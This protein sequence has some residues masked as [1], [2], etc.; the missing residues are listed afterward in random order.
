MFAAVTEEIGRLLGARTANM[1]RFDGGTAASVVGAW[2]DTPGRFVPVGA[3]IL[4]DSPTALPLVLTTGQTARV[5]DYSALTGAY[6]IRL[7]EMIGVKAAV[8]APIRVGGRLWGA[9]T[10][11]DA[12][13]TTRRRRPMPSS[14]SRRSP[15]S[16][17][18][19]SRTPRPS[20]S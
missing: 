19:R 13:T 2:S 11:S 8:A 17:R 4:L 9:I 12:S 10:V 7:R 14:A 16:S 20:A 15:S 5:D 3:E 18:R 6:A 1:V